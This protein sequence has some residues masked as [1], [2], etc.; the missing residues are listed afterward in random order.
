MTAET[1]ANALGGHRAG[2]TW[3]ACCPAHDD[4]KPSLSISTGKEGKVLVRCHAGCEQRDVIAALA[5][6]GLWKV[7]G[8]PSGQ[9]APKRRSRIATERDPDTAARTQAA[10]AIWRASQRIAGTPV[11]S[12]LRLRGIM[13]EAPPTLRFHQGLKHP[14]GGV[15]PAMVALVTDGETGSP[16]AVHRTFLDRDRGCKAPVD[17]AK[18]MLGPCRS[19]VVRLGEPG[20]SADGRRR[21]E[22]CLAAMQTSGHAAWSALSTSGLRSLRSAA[23]AFAT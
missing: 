9:V 1:I 3:M 19:G 23:R 14:S 20:A 18:M 16:I 8:E 4:R 2:A 7:A 15:W 5:D 12:Y 6:Q 11:E 17:P 10:L 13:L 22:T 21:I